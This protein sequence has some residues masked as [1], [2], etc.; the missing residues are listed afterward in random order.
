MLNGGNETQIKDQIL[1]AFKSKYEIYAW[2]S[3]AGNIIKAD[4]DFK[5]IKF[6]QK[7][8]V[9]SPKKISRPYLEDLIG[10]SGKINFAIPQMSLLFESE[11]LSYDDELIISF[12]K[13]Y[14]FY[15]RRKSERVDPFIPM[16]VKFTF[17]GIT[18][19]KKCNDIGIGGLS[20]VLNRNEMN[21]FMFGDE[22]K[23]LILSFPVKDIK[24]NVKVASMVK[25]NPFSNEK[26]PYGASRLSLSFTGNTSLVKKEI[27]K[28][29]NGQKKLVCDIE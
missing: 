9:L 13:Y 20:V 16:N 12:P 11:Y 10:G 25:L 5:T 26:T 28:I 17:K 21:K 4:L 3:F 8:I 22:I 2:G 15:D 29:I 14:K 18:F 19:N 1:E 27:L 6:N 23:D 24:T 7:K